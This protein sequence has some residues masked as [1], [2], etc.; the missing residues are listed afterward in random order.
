MKVSDTF[1]ERYTVGHISGPTLPHVSRLVAWF[2]ERGIVAGVMET[3]AHEHQFIVP[4]VWSDQRL[5]GRIEKKKLVYTLLADQLGL[6]LARE[7]S[8]DVMLGEWGETFAE[9]AD[10]SAA[11]LHL[12]TLQDDDEPET[13]SYIVSKAKHDTALGLAQSM[14]ADIEYA[15]AGGYA[16]W[17]LG[18]PYDWYEAGL[19]GSDLPA[20]VFQDGMVVV[21]Y[22][23]VT[24]PVLLAPAGDVR[25]SL[26]PDDVASDIAVVLREIAEYRTR[27]GGEIDTLVR[28]GIVKKDDVEALVTIL[29]TA[30]K[31]A[32]L[33]AKIGELLVLPRA[34][35]T[36]IKNG[37]MPDDVRVAKPSSWLRILGGFIERYNYEADPE[38]GWLQRFAVW[39]NAR[40]VL[41]WLWTLG[42]LAI[43]CLLIY[44]FML[45]PAEGRPWWHLVLGVVGIGCVLEAVVDVLMRVH[46]WRRQR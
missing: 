18:R 3:P 39:L 27:P 10:W 43:G 28:R 7:F 8:V 19:V 40:P 26:R 20:F 34:A 2:G 42:E 46:R 30:P 4:C 29:T 21:Q 13:L 12:H 22:G 33:Y 37:T 15:R 45:A 11:E 5:I 38:A 23:T 17:R 24:P 16:L 41:A 14:R 25:L 31:G 44:V 36:H 6:D 35:I 1:F 32:T 9:G